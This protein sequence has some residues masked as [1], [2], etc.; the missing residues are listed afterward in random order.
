MAT[1]TYNK[2]KEMLEVS[3]LKKEEVNEAAFER[4]T[5][6]GYPGCIEFRYNRDRHAFKYKLKDK[7]SL[8]VR[9][10]S[11]VEASEFYYLLHNM[12]QSLDDFF[13]VGGFPNFIDW[14]PDR[15][16]LDD[17]G[18]I[19]YIVYP[20]M[21]K[22]PEG[23]NV[24]TLFAS[25]IKNAKPLGKSDEEALTYL[26]RHV[27]DVE[28][29]KGSTED[30]L[31][32]LKAHVYSYFD[33]NLLDY[34]PSRLYAII[35]GV[36]T[37]EETRKKNEIRYEVQGI[38]LDMTDL[39]TDVFEKTT[40]ILPEEDD[41]STQLIIDDSVDYEDEVPKQKV[42]ILST[43]SSEVVELV[44][45][46]EDKTWSIGRRNKNGTSKANISFANSSISGIHCN[47]HF[48]NS[49]FYVEDLGSSNGTFIGQ[50]FD[51]E[52]K[53]RCHPNELMELENDCRL[54]LG[55]ETLTFKIEERIV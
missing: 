37:L 49:L 24:F 19:Y 47:I 11:T 36:E 50:P 39:D 35:N 34:K 18:R 10:G 14:S 28:T 45:D 43:A 16:F 15:V 53:T 51:S 1:I 25:L 48:A 41:E 3:L 55:T 44:A 30:F 46:S 12:F 27:K 42:G 5:S 31:A 33:S 2:A 26:Q 17:K 54:R 21:M 22:A 4:I 23:G 32:K 52:V 13:N 6:Q 40:L 38:S 8:R 29:G 20:L 9:L 7:I